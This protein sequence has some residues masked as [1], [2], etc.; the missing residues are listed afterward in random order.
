MYKIHHSRFGWYH[1]HGSWVPF[2][3]DALVLWGDAV[4]EFM[5]MGG[6][7][8]LISTEELKVVCL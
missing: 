3:A 7:G 2:E 4:L 5:T 8:E 1:G 6:V